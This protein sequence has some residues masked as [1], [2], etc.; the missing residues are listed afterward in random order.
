M[1][2][3]LSF[4]SCNPVIDSI[5][6]NIVKRT[7]NSSKKHTHICVWKGGQVWTLKAI[8]Q[9]GKN[10]FP[11]VEPYETK[12]LKKKV[13]KK[14]K[15]NCRLRNKNIMHNITLNQLKEKNYKKEVYLQKIVAF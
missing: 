3:F 6:W 7:K 15:K 4:F 10:A 2:F 9:K 1:L 13:P 11:M 12:K 14:T 8:F 5:K